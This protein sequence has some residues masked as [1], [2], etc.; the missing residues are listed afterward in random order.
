MKYIWSTIRVKNYEESI[1][2]YTKFL[3]L[4][5]INT[6]ETEE[7]IKIAFL[8]DGTSK[9]EIL[10]DNTKGDIEVSKDISLGFGV[11][12]LDDII[13]DL[14]NKNI[15]YIGPIQPNPNTR[16]IFIKDPN[17]IRIQLVEH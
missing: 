9:I 3:E 5:V 1:N 8:S 15:E 2:F 12:S 14:N 4:D 13:N 17:G 6:I 11:E 16:F 10:Y 7:G